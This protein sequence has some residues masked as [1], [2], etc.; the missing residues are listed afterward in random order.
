MRIDAHTGEGNGNPLQCSCLENPIDRG[1][2][3]PTV[4]RVSK[5]RIWLSDWECTAHTKINSKWI[6]DLNVI[7][8]CRR[9]YRG[10]TAWYLSWQWFYGYGTESVSNKSK[11]EQVG[12]YQTK[13]FLHIKGNNRVKRQSKDWEKIFASYISHKGLCSKL[14]NEFPQLHIWGGGSNSSI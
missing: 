4:H 14:Y 6:K 2:W 10:K 1:V 12:L 7:N 9:K 5:S 13:R 8:T 11:N 3:W